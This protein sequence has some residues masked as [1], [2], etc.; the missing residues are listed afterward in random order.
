MTA[1]VDTEYC[2][3]TKAVEHLGDRWCLLI[4][5]ELIV[6]GPMGFNALARGV[7]GHISRSVLADRLQ[8][9][10]DLG[11][12]S[13]SGAGDGAGDGQVA[14][15]LTGPGEALVPAFLALREWADDWLPDDPAMVQRDPEILLGWLAE[16]VRLQHLPE[17]Q[18]VVELSTRDEPVLRSWIVLQAGAEPYACLDDPMLDPARYVYLET[19]SATLLALA[20][21]RRDWRQA[22]DD[23]SVEAFGDPDLVRELPACFKPGGSSP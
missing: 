5:R 6:S 19:G 10:R 7:P 16:R 2:S 12:V 14:Y 4:M 1:T 23:G 11:L 20:R 13:R 8:R 9:L 22:L 15:R 3:F 17:R 18:V 21:G